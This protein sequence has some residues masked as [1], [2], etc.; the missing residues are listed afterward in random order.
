MF[1]KLTGYE[2]PV[3]SCIQSVNLITTQQVLRDLS[4][5]FLEVPC[6]FLKRII[7]KLFFQHK[8]YLLKFLLVRHRSPQV[9]QNKF[10]WAL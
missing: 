8:F 6:S 3:R 4:G 10:L 1:H 2:V 5:G 9:L 7:D